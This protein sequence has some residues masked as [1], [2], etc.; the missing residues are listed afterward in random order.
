MCFMRPYHNTENYPKNKWNIWQK[1]TKLLWDHLSGQVTFTSRRCKYGKTFL[2]HLVWPLQQTIGRQGLVIPTWESQCTWSPKT[3]QNTQH[4]SYGF[5]LFPSFGHFFSHLVFYLVGPLDSVSCFRS[6]FRSPLYFQDAG[7]I[8]PKEGDTDEKET[9][10]QTETK[11]EE[12]EEVE[13]EVEVE[14]NKE[15]IEQV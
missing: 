5:L 15:K 9:E 4:P 3:G 12:E 13:V 6:R 1:C 7:T 10:G 11:E 2:I 14:E 8:S